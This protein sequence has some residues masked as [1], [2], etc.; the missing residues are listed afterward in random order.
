MCQK[1]KDATAQMEPIFREVERMLAHRP[2]SEP[3]AGFL[4]SLGAVF[5][6]HWLLMA[7]ADLQAFAPLVGMVLLSAFYAGVQSAG[8]VTDDAG[9][10]EATAEGESH[11]PESDLFAE[12]FEGWDGP[13]GGGVLP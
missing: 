13:Q 12:W 11:I 7:V 6:P 10:S 1:C 2:L 5:N 3:E 8:G 4:A 9:A